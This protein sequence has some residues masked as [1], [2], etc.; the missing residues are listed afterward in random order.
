MWD[1]TVTMTH[2][3]IYLLMMQLYMLCHLPQ[4]ALTLGDYRILSILLMN[5]LLQIY[6]SCPQN[7]QVESTENMKKVENIQHGQSQIDC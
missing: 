3:E 5:L 7:L 4:L 6:D 2:V 1:A